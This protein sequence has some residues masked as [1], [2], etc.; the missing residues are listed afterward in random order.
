MVYQ[1]TPPPMDLLSYCSWMNGFVHGAVSFSSSLSGSPF[2]SLFPPHNP[3]CLLH[4]DFE[5]AGY[6]NHP[7]SE[8]F[9][10]LSVPGPFMQGFFLMTQTSPLNSFIALF[11][12]HS[13]LPPFFLSF[14]FLRTTEKSPDGISACHIVMK[15]EL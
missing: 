12:I 1:S 15:T 4:W 2:T 14:R 13:F 10:A 8:I 9:Q 3:A 6:L 7:L 5:S 11:F